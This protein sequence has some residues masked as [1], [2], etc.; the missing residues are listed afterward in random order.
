M[1][2]T[3]KPQRSRA[4]RSCG[5]CRGR[6]IRCDR[7]V[8]ACANCAT[9]KLQCQG[10]GLRLSWP[11]VGDRKRALLVPD[12][13][14]RDN[15]NAPP[16]DVSNS[17]FFINM[18]HRHVAAHYNAM[19]SSNV[20]VITQTVSQNQL[21]KS[22]PLSLVDEKDT[23][24]LHYYLQNAASFFLNPLGSLA[25]LLLQVGLA[26]SSPSSAAVLNGLLAISAL[27]VS[28]EERAI[29]FKTKA[30]I[31][32][33]ASLNAEGSGSTVIAKLAA[34][35]LLYLYET[36]HMSSP[37]AWSTYLGGVKQILLLSTGCSPFSQ[38]YQT[39]L[40]WIIYHETMAK[41]GQL[42]WPKDGGLTPFC[43][44][45]VS[46]LFRK[47]ADY[48]RDAEMDA[49]GC[50]P[51]ILEVISNIFDLTNGKGG[52]VASQ[53]AELLELEW[54]LRIK[55]K[56]LP[57]SGLVSGTSS[58]M[59]AITMLH[60]LAAQ[61]WVNR[62]VNGYL[63]TEGSHQWLVAQAVDILG[64]L[65]ICDIPW[66][67]FIIAGEMRT[68]EQRRT[69]LNIIVRTQERSKSKHMDM[70]EELVEATWNYN[71]L[72]P[73]GLLHYND[74]LRCVIQAYPWILPFT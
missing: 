65:T 46:S 43:H 16:G 1:S 29:K 42:Y 21:P 35:M 45:R 70:V 25:Q 15:C 50:D 67:L 66:P 47:H 20:R 9:A 37:K 72:D 34:S 33:Q 48:E 23:S 4:N 64:Q 73:S 3:E 2:N 60:C 40:D 12:L 74:K 8:P 56:R 30:I 13:G 10:Y 27:H 32:T 7:Q 31:M 71:D 44:K 38:S 57:E 22:I 5:N 41:F 26:D 6:R 63:G 62:S 11:R 36:L 51:H 53:P 17:R 24:L 14:P 18:Q 49:T 54:E 19:S 39:V 28:G 52:F 55:L 61:L 68:E 59:H 58:W 69:M